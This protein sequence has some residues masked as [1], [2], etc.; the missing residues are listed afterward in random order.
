M[1][2]NEKRKSV[3]LKIGFGSALFLLALVA[4][5]MIQIGRAHV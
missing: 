5:A 1:T 2:P 3:G 4:V